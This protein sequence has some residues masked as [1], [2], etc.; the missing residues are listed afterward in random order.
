M[1]DDIASAHQLGAPRALRFKI[2]VRN[3]AHKD[4][5]GDHA[6]VEADGAGP[7]GAAPKRER[8][9]GG[10]EA[11]RCLVGAGAGAGD[12]AEAVETQRIRLVRWVAHQGLLR[13]ADPV[14]LVNR[15]AVAEGEGLCGFAGHRD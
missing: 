7:L 5:L 8:E 9:V 1:E 14:I 4:H 15:G 11:V 13:H 6:H 10:P 3:E 12:V 2:N